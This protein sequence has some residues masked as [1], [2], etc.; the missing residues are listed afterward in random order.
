VG[1]IMIH[2][3]TLSWQGASYLRAL[4]P[5][6]YYNAQNLF[7]KGIETRWHVRDNGSTDDSIQAIVEHGATV[8]SI[9]HNRDNYAVGMNYLFNNSGATDDDILLLLNNDV[10]FPEEDSLFKMLEL[11]KNNVGVVGARLLYLNTNKLQHAG[12]IF[13]ERY[14]KM[15]YHYRHKEISDKEAERNREFQAVTA[16]CCMVRASDWRK[17]GGMSEEYCW[18]F[19]DIDFCLKI[20]KTLGKK[21]MYCGETKI[22]HEESVSLKKNPINTLMMPQNVKKFKDKWFGKYEIDHDKYL[23]NKDYLAR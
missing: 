6:L 4:A 21:I 12:V 23:T 20:G 18:C 22:F 7:R 14:G 10:I 8:Y 13:G 19:D 11:L 9:G 5:G 1:E 3:L 17:V 15:P 2:I 16:A